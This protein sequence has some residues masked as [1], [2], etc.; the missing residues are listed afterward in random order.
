[1]TS[2]LFR[3]GE[4]VPAY[5][6]AELGGSVR[7]AGDP[8][9]AFGYALT[10][11]QNGDRALFRSVALD[12]EESFSLNAR[13]DKPCRAEVYLDG[14]YAGCAKISPSDAFASVSGSLEHPVTGVREA[15]LR[16]YGEDFTAALD[17]LAFNKR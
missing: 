13:T 2:G 17:S 6:A 9:S 10:E 12:G 11:I 14:R 5:R 1:M 7:I 3:S 15:E 16:F 4:T 8:Q